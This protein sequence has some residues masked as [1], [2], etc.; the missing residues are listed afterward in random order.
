MIDDPVRAVIEAARAYRQVSEAEPDP[1][2]ST[3]R[4]PYGE[5]SPHR[6][7]AHDLDHQ[8]DLARERLFEVLADYERRLLSDAADAQDNQK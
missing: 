2:L 8:V 7:A 5:P 1:G 6:M 4:G 3:L